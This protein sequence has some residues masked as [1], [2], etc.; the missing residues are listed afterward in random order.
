MKVLFLLL[1]CALIV[2]TSVLGL[3]LPVRALWLSLSVMLFADIIITV[4]RIKNGKSEK[5]N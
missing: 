1:L 2:M 3:T 4:R 5:K